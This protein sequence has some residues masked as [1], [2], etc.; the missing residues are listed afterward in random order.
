MPDATN[1]HRIA[2]IAQWA[3]AG[4]MMGYP[5]HIIFQDFPAPL[6]SEVFHRLVGWIGAGHV[7]PVFEMRNFRELYSKL[8]S[9]RLVLLHDAKQFDR[10]SWLIDDQQSGAAI[11]G[12]TRPVVFSRQ[13]A[14]LAEAVPGAMLVLHGFT[15]QRKSLE[16]WLLRESPWLPLT[17]NLAIA[18]IQFDQSLRSLGF[19]QEAA[20][21]AV[22]LGLR[23]RRILKGLLM[24]TALVRKIQVGNHDDIL[25]VE[26]ADYQDVFEALQSSAIQPADE[27][28]DPLA[29][30]MVERANAYLSM[31]ADATEK[32]LA[33]ADTPGVVAEEGRTIT[34][35]EIVDL[36]TPHGTLV[37]KLLAFLLQ[38]GPNGFQIFCTIGTLRNFKGQKDW[39]TRDT[40][41]L[42]KLLLPWGRKQVRN[43]FDA[44][45]ASGLITGRR[46][47]GN[48]P[49]IYEL[50]EALANP[51][52][53][54][55]CLPKPED[56]H[57][58]GNTL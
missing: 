8:D 41:E 24:G 39:P 23:E 10:I 31:K 28:F 54:L 30:A 36:G 7:F 17:V 50:P 52:S 19:N 48:K 9:T 5:V 37:E 44:L 1:L 29:R 32:K 22:I 57:R 2:A 14:H 20:D 47:A 53:P 34:R 33:Q 58:D 43:Q 13:T 18:A 26:L 21:G 51:T 46:D 27:S 6:V 42:A 38:E 12:R 4:G 49:W 56:L 11:V 40:Q 16:D 45:H 15:A 3:I 35:R 25:R 55:R